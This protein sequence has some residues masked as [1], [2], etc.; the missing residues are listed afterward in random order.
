MKNNSCEV[1]S[2]FKSKFSAC[3]DLYSVNEE[4]KD[5]F[6]LMDNSTAWVFITF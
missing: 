6:G 3:Y 2:E 1:L 5:P 4:D